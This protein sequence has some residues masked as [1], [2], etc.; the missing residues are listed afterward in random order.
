MQK[1]IDV[2]DMHTAIHS[3]YI[4]NK[5]PKTTLKLFK[6]LDDCCYDYENETIWNEIMKNVDSFDEINWRDITGDMFWT[7]GNLMSHNEYHCGDNHFVLI[8]S[9]DIN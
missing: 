9:F 8:G 5:K 4:V 6:S 1:V 7:N 2:R 3:L